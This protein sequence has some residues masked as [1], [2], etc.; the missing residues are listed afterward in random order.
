VFVLCSICTSRHAAGRKAARADILRGL[1]AK[2]YRGG[3]LGTGRDL[4]S[5]AGFTLSS[6]TGS[7]EQHHQRHKD[8]NAARSTAMS[9]NGDPITGLVCRRITSA[10]ILGPRM[11]APVLA[12]SSKQSGLTSKR[13][14]SST[15]KG[16][17][18]CGT[19]LRTHGYIL[20][21]HCAIRKRILFNANHSRARSMDH[22]SEKS[23]F[24]TPS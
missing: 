14:W 5:E 23:T 6:P 20:R 4:T 18:T 3:T 13:S 21:H 15:P 19:T 16:K 2:E 12:H 24:V 8:Q 17:R 1:G 7:S 22:E 10:M 11:L 9:I